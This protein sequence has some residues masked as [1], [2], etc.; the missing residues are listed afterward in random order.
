MRDNN[1]NQNNKNVNEVSNNIM[2]K[3]VW[4]MKYT[5]TIFL[6]TIVLV[7]VY[8]FILMIQNANSD[9]MTMFGLIVSFLTDTV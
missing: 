4:V 5:A 8:H 2:Q 6:G 9:I 3:A 7:F 1:N